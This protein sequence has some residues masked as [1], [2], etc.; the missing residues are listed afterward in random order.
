MARQVI[1]LTTPQPGGRQGEPTASAWT[2][3]NDMTLELYQGNAVELG[4]AQRTTPFT[5]T[6]TA[7]VP[8]LLIN[9]TAGVNPVI[10][11]FGATASVP[12]NTGVL[13]VQVDGVQIAQLL[14]APDI[15]FSTLS[16]IGRITGKTPGQ[17]VVVKLVATSSGGN[18]FQVFGD[19]TD[20]S[21]VRVT[22]A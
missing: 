19:P 21:Y 1:D 12:G 15:G 4:Y 10:V 6:G 9:Y 20:P 5:T 16:R 22:S 3:V 2:K 13:A 11:E 7:D 14:Y 18:S 8:G 17:N